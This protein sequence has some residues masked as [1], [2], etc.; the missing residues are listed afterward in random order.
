LSF[1]EAF[2]RVEPI[3]DEWEQTAM[4]CEKIVFELYAQA[5]MDPPSWEDL[6]PPRYKR[7]RKPIVPTKQQAAAS[8]QTLLK[9]TKLDGVANNG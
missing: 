7:T 1:W 9:A 6:M 8:F 2:D 3:G 4:I 5:K